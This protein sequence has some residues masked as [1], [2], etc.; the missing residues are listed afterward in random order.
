MLKRCALNKDKYKFS[1]KTIPA[2]QKALVITGLSLP[3]PV[4][5]P[6]HG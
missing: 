4:G 6:V 1:S 3:G 2:G 5:H